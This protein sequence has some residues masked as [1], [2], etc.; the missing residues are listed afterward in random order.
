MIKIGL[1]L[2]FIV[3]I[4]SPIFNVIANEESEPV[5]VDIEEN[6]NANDNVTEEIK[7]LPS[8]DVITFYIFP[9]GTEKNEFELG[10]KIEFLIGFNNSGSSVFNITRI[11]GSFM[12]PQDHRY[13]IQNFT[14]QEIPIIVQSNEFRTLL[15]TFKP[16]PLLDPYREYGLVV[17]V[18]YTDNEGSN[19]TNVIFNTTITM[20]ESSE[21]FDFQLLFTYV[22]IL[23]VVGL[24][25]FVVYNSSRKTM[26]KVKRTEFGT[27]KATIADTEWLEGTNAFVSN[28]AKNT[29]RTSP[30]GSPKSKPKKNN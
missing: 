30:P 19:F 13:F 11:Q 6:N 12:Y 14:K 3:L 1:S 18:F 24:V 27:K 26:K 29:S 25:G 16:D 10:R 28:N 20:I 23:G 7:I 22:G 21:T 8:P 2:L 9:N 15:Y 4:V 5:K 17:S